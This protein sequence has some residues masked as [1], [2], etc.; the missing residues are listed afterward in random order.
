M[1]PSSSSNTRSARSLS[2]IRSAVASSSDSWTPSSTSRPR[3]MRP[4]TSPSTATDAEATRWTT[5]RISRG[6]DYSRGRPSVADADRLR[7]PRPVASD[8]DVADNERSPSDAPPG[9]VGEALAAQLDAGDPA[10]T[11]RQPVRPRPERLAAG[12]QRDPAV[13]AD[14]GRW[15]AADRDSNRPVAHVQRGA[16]DGQRAVLDVVAASA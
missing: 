15:R 3:P 8:V 9:D 14:D 7:R 16:A 12:L 13:A 6:S 1:R 2:A 11:R 10:A 4:A 5:A